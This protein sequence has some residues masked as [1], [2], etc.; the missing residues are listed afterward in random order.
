MR[1]NILTIILLCLVFCCCSQ[2]INKEIIKGD[3]YRINPKNEKIDYYEI[4]IGKKEINYYYIVLGT[5]IKYSYLKSDDSNKF[6]MIDESTDELATFRY[7][8]IKNNSELKLTLIKDSINTYDFYFKKLESTKR[9]S[10]FFD[11]KI[12]QEEYES[13]AYQRKLRWVK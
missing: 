1:K 10:D 4:R 8:L 9:M 5:Y 2:D 7:E 6:Y 11:N 12:S 13:A 3:W